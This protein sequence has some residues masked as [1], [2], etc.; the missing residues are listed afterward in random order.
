MDEEPDRERRREAKLETRQHRMMQFWGGPTTKTGSLIWMTLRQQ[1][2]E[3]I[4]R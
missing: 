2:S 3:S 4:C 1:R